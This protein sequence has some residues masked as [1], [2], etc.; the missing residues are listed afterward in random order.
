MGEQGIAAVANDGWALAEAKGLIQPAQYVEVY[1]FEPFANNVLGHVWN[2]KPE[3]ADTLW[4]AID[5]YDWQ[6]S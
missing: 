1:E 4:R 5:N 3:L 2:L 6:S